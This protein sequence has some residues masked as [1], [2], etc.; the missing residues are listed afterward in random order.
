MFR[1]G[2][3]E[4]FCPNCLTFSV[5]FEEHTEDGIAGLESFTVWV[6]KECGSEVYD[7]HD[8]L[9]NYYKWDKL[10]TRLIDARRDSSDL[11]EEEES[12]HVVYTEQKHRY[13]P[14]EGIYTD[15]EVARH[16]ATICGGTVIDHYIDQDVEELRQGKK[17]FSCGTKISLPEVLFTRQLETVAERGD[18]WEE[19]L[20]RDILYMYCWALDDT[21]AEHVALQVREEY[22]KSPRKWK[23]MD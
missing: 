5:D 18:F 21:H 20:D 17:I 15:F 23:Y 16:V 14:V 10:H 3:D 7:P 12:Y 11:L 13:L 8:I 22:L 2:K 4:V 9:E 1:V 6:C 19:H